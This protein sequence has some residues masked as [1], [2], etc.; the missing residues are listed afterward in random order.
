[1]CS[2]HPLSHFCSPVRFRRTGMIARFRLCFPHFCFPFLCAIL[3]ENVRT[4]CILQSNLSAH[5]N[6]VR[7][8]TH[9]CVMWA[10][11]SRFFFRKRVSSYV[12]HDSYIRSGVLY[13]SC[14]AGKI[15][16]Q[17]YTR[18]HS[19]IQKVTKGVFHCCDRCLCNRFPPWQALGAD[20]DSVAA[21]LRGDPG[22]GVRLDV[23][24]GG[25]AMAFPLSR[26]QFKVVVCCLFVF[27][28]EFVPRWRTPLSSPRWS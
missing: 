19:D 15:Q 26:A 28:G 7:R 27:F 22:T 24:R 10:V 23:R 4:Y 21:M 14:L 5:Y 13:S 12:C 20:L 11:R 16:Y 1:M 3:S 17:W 2:F 8:V 18:L 25:K 9:V 6:W